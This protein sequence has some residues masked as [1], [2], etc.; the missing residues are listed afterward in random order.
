[1]HEE[2]TAISDIRF[3]LTCYC[4]FRIFD[5]PRSRFLPFFIQLNERRIIMKK[6]SWGI[7]SVPIEETTRRHKAIRELTAFRIV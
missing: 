3:P 5:S 6:M 2:D 7:L 1:M 4:P